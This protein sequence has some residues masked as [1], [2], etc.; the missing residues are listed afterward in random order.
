MFIGE[1]RSCSSP[2]KLPKFPSRIPPSNF[3]TI[4]VVV[5][6]R[7]GYRPSFPSVL[8]QGLLLTTSSHNVHNVLQDWIVRF[9]RT[10]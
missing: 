6:F 9:C 4:G 2:Q 1:Y 10:T 3:C 8:G 7:V 5:R